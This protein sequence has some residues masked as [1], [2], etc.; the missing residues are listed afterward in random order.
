M[1]FKDLNVL[2]K[3]FIDLQS[4]YTIK[5]ILFFCADKNRPNSI[6]IEKIL[7]LN[8]KPLIGG[9]FP[10]ILADGERKETGFLIIPLF[11]ELEVLVI[12]TN[13]HES[14]TYQLTTQ[15]NS[16]SKDF[17]SV[18]CFLNSLWQE[19]TTFIQELYNEL[20]PFYQY[21]GGGAGSLSF[22]SF[23]CVFANQN[24]HKNSAV[25]GF[26]KNAI[27]LGVCHGWKQISDPIKVTESNGNKIISLDWK[28][29]FEVYKL[30]VE[31]HSK[32]RFN[33]DN[34]FEISKSYPLGLVKLEGEMIVR[35]P[36]ATDNNLLHI[37]DQIREGE[38]IRI[39]HGDITSLLQSA[40][41]A[42]EISSNLKLLKFTQFCVDCVSRVLFME[43]EFDKEL[44]HLNTHKPIN[45]VLA[46]GEIAS[47][48]NSVLEIFNK[49]I[50]VAQ[51]KENY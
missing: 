5:G 23:P 36:F 27:S 1:Y 39:L 31:K 30:N 3:V 33:D 7:K 21:L 32:K 40:K 16:L 51:W 22:E 14:I 42:V 11:Q 20:G 41:D 44:N 12:E 13:E 6:E 24:V 19:K 26:F 4:D 25:L 48:G 43:S 28:P 35:D 38:F 10:E 45:G 18:F 47:L 34:F 17:E 29:A 46:L 2:K 50:C 8:T 9:V 37:L 49:T 15:L